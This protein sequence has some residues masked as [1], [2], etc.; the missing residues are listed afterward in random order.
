M[1]TNVFALICLSNLAAML[2]HLFQPFLSLLIYVLF[3]VVTPPMVGCGVYVG[4]PSILEWLLCACSSVHFYVLCF[5][6]VGRVWCTH[7]MLGVV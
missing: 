3:A 2:V 6:L 1:C 7:S 4:A 5:T